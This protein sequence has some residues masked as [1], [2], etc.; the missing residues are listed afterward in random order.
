[1]KQNLALI[2]MLFFLLAAAMGSAD[3]SGSRNITSDGAIVEVTAANVST[4]LGALG[5]AS[6]SLASG[7]E[8]ETQEEQT[9]P[10]V[11]VPEPPMLLLLG[12]ALV[13]IAALR[14]R[15]VS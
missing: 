12:I 8:E 4:L 2:L 3:P 5:Y 11:R 14:F 9:P 6:S 15:R 1:L 13:V 7:R 10:R